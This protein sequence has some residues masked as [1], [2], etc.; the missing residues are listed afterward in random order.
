MWTNPSSTKA[1][2]SMGDIE[3]TRLYSLKRQSVLCNEYA[4]DGQYW[5]KTT[6]YF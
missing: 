4:G 1:L 2:E 6:G 3:V 5:L